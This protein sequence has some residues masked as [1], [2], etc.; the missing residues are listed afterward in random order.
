MLTQQPQEPCE[1]LTD[2]EQRVVENERRR[3]M[4]T[5]ED[6]SALRAEVSAGVVD[7]I[8][9]LLADERAIKEFWRGGYTELSEHTSNGA[10]QWVGKRILTWFVT[11]IFT[12]A[13]VYLLTKGTAPGSKP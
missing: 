5:K 10:T 2:L 6:L 9:T 12:L 1:A 11:G 8:K 4:L 7:G 13:A 3:H